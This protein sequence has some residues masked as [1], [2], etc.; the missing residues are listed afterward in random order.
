MGIHRQR[1]EYLIKDRHLGPVC[2]VATLFAS[3]VAQWAPDRAWPSLALAGAIWIGWRLGSQNRRGNSWIDLAAGL[4][5]L[6]MFVGVWAAFNRETAW[7]KFWILLA[8]VLLYLAISRQSA[9][10][11]DLSVTLLAFVGIVLAI[12]F[13]LFRAGISFGPLTPSSQGSPPSFRQN[14]ADGLW[15][16]FVP[17]LG[18]A[19]LDAWRQ[20]RRSHTLI[21]LI[22]FCIALFTL[23]LSGSRGAWVSLGAASVIAVL[24]TAARWL[25]RRDRVKA[26]WIFCVEILILGFLMIVG[27]TV[28]GANATTLLATRIDRA[29]PDSRVVVARNSIMLAEDYPLIG[30]GL[31]SFP[32]L[33]SE[34]ILV[35]PVPRVYNSHTLYLD[36]LL[37]Q[38]PIGLGSMLLSFLAG[39]AALRT[40]ARG[41]PKPSPGLRKLQAGLAVGLLV[42]LIQGLWDD[43]FYGNLATPWLLVFPGLAAAWMGS[44]ADQNLPLPDGAKIGQTLKLIVAVLVVTSALALAL[45]F[46]PALISAWYA[47]LGAVEMARN[48]LQNWPTGQWDDGQGVDLL[49]KA[50]GPLQSALAHDPDNRTAHHRLGL[51][52]MQQRDFQRAASHLELALAQTPNHRGL[53]K[54]L[55]FSYTWAGELERAAP[56]L[57]QIP[58]AEK[59][60]H[61]YVNWWKSL[62][63]DELSVR[64]QNM[65]DLLDSDLSVPPAGAS[66][67]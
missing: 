61:I 27:L 16:S 10:N 24:W 36:L 26:I 48:Q 57:A 38:G 47:N 55:G 11:L 40:S 62:G 21:R 63:F 8:A 32:G 3:L 15:A 30:A 56:L 42:F 4:F 52:Q 53:I 59:E 66:R 39:L 60:L 19:S 1:L 33:Y 49:L 67:P 31:G 23:G 58:E 2:L 45:P 14:F 9:G 46:R 17:L 44:T 64:A 22:A 18:L 51:I 50:K 35:I 13:I 7:G 20:G 28:A 29:G 37:E 41:Y 12:D 6:S 43:P 54:A 34:Y 5:L 25:A 65:A